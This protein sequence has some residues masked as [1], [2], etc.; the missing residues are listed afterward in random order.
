[1]YDFE[2]AKVKEFLKRTGAKRAALQV[3]AGLAPHLPEIMRPFDQLGV[4]VV[5]MAGSCY[6]ACDLADEAAKKL[7]SDVLVHYGHADMGLESVLPTLFV[8]ARIEKSPIESLELA[9]PEL[10]FKRVG[11]VA[12]VQHVGHLEEAANFLELHGIQTFVGGPSTRT[13]YPGQ[14]LG[15]DVGCAKAVAPMVEGF[16][17]IGT[18]EFHPLGVA[19]V[20]GKKVVAVN[21]VS[22][23]FKIF[24]PQQD[25]FIKERKAMVAR[26]ALG[27][28]FG[29]IVS[30]KK[31]QSRFNLASKIVD[32][33]RREGK[34]TYLLAVDDISPEV[35][36]NFGFDAL[37]LV[38]CPRIPVDDAERFESP[39]LTPFEVLVMLGKLPIEP[40]RM[41]EIN[42]ED[43]G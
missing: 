37:V 10:R 23:S 1:M 5:I 42:K 25:E 21:P 3:P 43:M 20:T 22:V 17:Y 6:G 33:L 12:T 2:E 19:L 26:A 39:V 28:T 16:I 8:E 41:D 27:K 13:R 4:E 14:V 7:G 11:L 30:T 29:V 34:R 24:M 18:G 36:K 9:L 38:A 31:G 35:M 32:L 40:Y 15:C